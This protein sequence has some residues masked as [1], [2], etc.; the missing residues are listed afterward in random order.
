M[1]V[2][3][4]CTKE[5]FSRSKSHLEFLRLEPINRSGVDDDI[6][7]VESCTKGGL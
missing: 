1:G 4:M 7:E 3:I 6:I 5:S 2:Q